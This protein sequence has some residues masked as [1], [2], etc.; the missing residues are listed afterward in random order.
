M[1][2][3]R[4]KVSCYYYICIVYNV[5]VLYCD[6]YS[7]CYL[8]NIYFAQAKYVN[9]LTGPNSDWSIVREPI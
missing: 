7:I 5:I 3:L 4:N 1:L 6:I 9:Q 8:A 2:S